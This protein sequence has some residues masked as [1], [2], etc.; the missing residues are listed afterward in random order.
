MSSSSEEAAQHLMRN[1]QFSKLL[2]KVLGG[3]GK[4]EE[5]DYLA[6][7]PKEGDPTREEWLRELQEKLRQEATKEATKELEKVHSD[8]NGQWMYVLPNPGFCI[9]CRAAGGSKVF[10]NIAHHARIGEPMPMAPEKGENGELATRFRVPLSCGQARRDK[11]KGGK[12]CKVYDVIVNTITMKRCNN[13][14]EF[15]R[16]VAALCIQWIQQKYEPTLNAEEFINVNFKVKGTL[17][18]QRIRLSTTPKAANVMQDEITL[19][20]AGSS[21]STPSLPSGASGAGKLIEELNDDADGRGECKEKEKNVFLTCDVAKTTAAVQSANK[22]SNQISI[23]VL[24]SPSVIHIQ[25]DGFYDWSA[26]AKPMQNPMFK[27]AVPSRY[28]LQLHIPTVQSIK[29]VNVQLTTKKL[30]CYYID[31]SPDCV[32]P[33]LTV[34]FDYPV[35]EEPE[36]AKFVRS[37]SILKMTVR[38]VLPDET[39]EPRTKPSRDADEEEREENSKEA[40]K[41]RRQ[42]ELEKKKA[43]RLIEQE[44]KVMKERKSMVENLA[45]LQSGCLPPALKEDIDGMPHAQLPAML[46]RLESRKRM[47]DSIDALL[48]K[49]PDEVH[50]SITEYI[51][52]KLSLEPR[53]KIEKR[54]VAFSVEEPEV[55]S[56]LSCVTSSA[57]GVS[58]SSSPVNKKQQDDGCARLAIHEKNNRDFDDG[59][60]AD[61]RTYNYAKRSKR[62]FGIEFHNRYL[63]ALD[64]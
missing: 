39:K 35:S 14:H 36:E 59:E 43:N 45:A 10:I 64:S 37:K 55:S 3:N 57:S 23:N 6:S 24:A 41:R 47:G 18:P 1:P 17:E 53:Q 11:D 62:L 19:P 49:L 5:Q 31:Q 4:K 52:E 2:Q 51:R 34:I 9:K 16:F 30:E 58:P 44:E 46:H 8:S 56:S 63:F 38:V 12:P 32:E 54:K 13:E 22:S 33:F 7:M 26:H 27:E 25:K 42:Y 61:F 40:E 21:G 20:S 50:N 28:K 60:S 15:R 48:E 29:E